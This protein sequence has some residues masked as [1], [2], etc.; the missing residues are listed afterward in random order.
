[1]NIYLRQIAFILISMVFNIG[2]QGQIKEIT[3]GEIPEE[4]LEMT[5][6]TPDPSADA[7]I[8]ENYASVSMRSAEKIL[9]ITDRHIRIKIINTDGQ[10]GRAHV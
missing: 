2:L 9:V 10:I 4:D 8:L 5:E 6:Y 3:F 1:M 7:V